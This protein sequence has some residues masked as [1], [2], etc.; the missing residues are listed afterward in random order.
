[1]TKEVVNIDLTTLVSPQTDL[2]SGRSLGESEAKKYAVVEHLKKKDQIVITIDDSY[3]KA[4]ND[5]FI[6]GFFSQVFKEMISKHS[7]ETLV[8]IE[9]NDYFNRLFKKN[10]TILEALYGSNHTSRA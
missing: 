5:S 6:K 9:S 4:I 2:I 10:W 8:T 3:V 7:V 1:M